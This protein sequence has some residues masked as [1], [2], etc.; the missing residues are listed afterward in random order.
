MKVI[1]SFPVDFSETKQRGFLVLFFCCLNSQLVGMLPY[2][3][4]KGGLAKGLVPAYITFEFN[5]HR[6]CPDEPTHA[7]CSISNLFET[8]QETRV[9]T[10]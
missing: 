9:G 8:L 7:S 4:Q 10:G 1:G 3:G 5:P 6:A 2:H